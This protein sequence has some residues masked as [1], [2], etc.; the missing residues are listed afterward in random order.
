MVS[1]G[2][3]M[4]WGVVGWEDDGGEALD[5]GDSTN[6]GTNL[7]K[8]QVFRGR[9]PSQP[10]D[11]AQAQGQRLL[12]QLADHVSLPT[13]GTRVM[14]AIPEH[15]GMIPG[16]SLIVGAV[17]KDRQA[18]AN[19]GAGEMIIQAPGGAAAIILKGD[20]I[21]LRT[22]DTKGNTTTF[23]VA[24]GVQKT[25]SPAFL[26]SYDKTGMRMRHWAGATLELGAI[27]LSGPLSA[28]ST[29]ATIKAGRVRVDGSLVT[30][31]PHFGGNLFFPA[32]YGPDP[33]P[34]PLTLLGI[35]SSSVKLSP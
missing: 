23:V 27:G 3:E 2:S 34:G 20:T 29:M 24:P 32:A 15:Y 10:L 17:T 7:V 6:D 9:D 30:I 4:V 11:A 14:V 25:T 1:T 19:V 21:V 8:V 16:G 33:A 13:D 22:A 26:V 35:M 28:L 12:C 18:N 5:L 31:G